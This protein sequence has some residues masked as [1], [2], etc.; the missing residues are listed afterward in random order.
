[1]FLN[2]ELELD[3]ELNPQI[4]SSTN[5]SKSQP[6]QPISSKSSLEMI[7]L[8]TILLKPSQITRVLASVASSSSSSSLSSESIDFV[9]KIFKGVTTNKRA[10]LARSITLIETTN[11][12]KK[13]L[14]QILLNKV[15][16]KLKRDRET[17]K[18]TCLRVG[19]ILSKLNYSGSNVLHFHLICLHVGITG[20][21]GAGKSSLIEKFGKYL[22]T[23]EM[24]RVA[25]LT[26]DPSSTSTGGF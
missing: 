12:E 2:D 17:S 4:E 13:I 21:P 20:P 9:E 7:T 18:T 1:M 11:P 23:K 5:L 14:A 16:H 15:L 6:P 26:V 8:R 3:L 22:T 10:D 19:K 24:A 25:V